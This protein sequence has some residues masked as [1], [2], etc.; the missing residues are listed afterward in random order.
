MPLSRPRLRLPVATVLPVTFAQPA[1]AEAALPAPSQLPVITGTQRDGQKLGGNNGTWTGTTPM[2]FNKRWQRCD[3]MGENCVEIPNEI[4]AS[5]TLQTADV[6]QT[7]RLAVTAINAEGRTTSQSLPTD[8]IIAKQPPTNSVLPAI[9][10]TMRDT[11]VLT[12]TNGDWTGIPTI[13][14][15]R[16]WLRCEPGAP[17]T[18]CTPLA[19]G[20]QTYMLT[21]ADVDMTMREIGRASCRERV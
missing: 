5:Y 6:G 9:T 1:V 16:K 7:I 18:E 21:S 8:T 13:Q 3:E 4:G 15:T 12:T 19:A 2:T 11:Q 10:G 20:G 17:A 14:F